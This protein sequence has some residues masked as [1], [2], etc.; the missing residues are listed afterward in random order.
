MEPRLIR[1]PA[2]NGQFRLS[3]QKA[4]IFSLKLTRFMRTAV[5]TDNRHGYVKGKNY[6]L[7]TGYYTQKSV[8]G[9]AVVPV[10]VKEPGS[11]RTVKT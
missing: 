3:R 7:G 4:R 1:T 9:L 5:N 6:S 8:I 2:Y 10:K 11:E